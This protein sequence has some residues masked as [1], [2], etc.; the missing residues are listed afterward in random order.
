MLAILHEATLVDDML[1]SYTL[2]RETSSSSTFGASQY[3]APYAITRIDP[4]IA[5]DPKVFT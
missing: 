2:R 3:R 5:F 4:L 1:S